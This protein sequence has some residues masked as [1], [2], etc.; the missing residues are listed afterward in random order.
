[1]EN[2]R[3]LYASF[4]FVF[5]YLFVVYKRMSPEITIKNVYQIA[6][7]PKNLHRKTASTNR[8][9][10]RSL[11]TCNNCSARPTLLVQNFLDSFKKPFQTKYLF[12]SITTKLCGGLCVSV[13]VLSFPTVL[14]NCRP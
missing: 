12:H 1:M 6:I 10:V 7:K 5:G 3:F 11:S 4:Y 9:L 2:A 14:R 13:Y 8:D